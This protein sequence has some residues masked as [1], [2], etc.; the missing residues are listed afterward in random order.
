MEKQ[1]RLKR[2]PFCNGAGKFAQGLGTTTCPLCQ[3]RGE[4]EPEWADYEAGRRTRDRAKHLIVGAFVGILVGGIITRF[5]GEL[6][7]DLVNR[8]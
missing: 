4:V 7:T 5:G 2:C 6:A 3:G 1:T 8:P